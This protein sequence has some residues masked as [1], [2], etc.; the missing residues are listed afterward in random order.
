MLQFSIGEVIREG[1]VRATEVRSAA[2][3]GVSAVPSSHSDSRDS[4]DLCLSLHTIVIGT[5]DTHEVDPRR[6]SAPRALLSEQ[7]MGFMGVWTQVA[8]FVSKWVPLGQA[9]IRHLSWPA[10]RE[11][12]RQV[13]HSKG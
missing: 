3:V 8:D 2:P 12:N 1:S 10:A 6:Y 5:L 11:A 9:G 7:R 13:A 4:D